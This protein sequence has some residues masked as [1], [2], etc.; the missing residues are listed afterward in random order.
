M[1]TF[2]AVYLARHGETAWSLSGQHTGLT[3]LA[4]RWIGLETMYAAALALS[5]ASLSVLGYENGL[6]QPAILLW[7]DTSH[8]QT[9]TAHPTSPRTESA[10]VAKV[11]PT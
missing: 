7:N 1:N 10:P 8:V 4:A 3:D 6:Q 11:H 9:T 2:P 5:T